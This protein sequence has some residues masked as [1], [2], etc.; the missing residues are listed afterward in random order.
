MVSPAGTGAET[1]DTRGVKADRIPAGRL[2]VMAFTRVSATCPGSWDMTL[3]TSMVVSDPDAE[4]VAHNDTIIKIRASGLIKS[5]RWCVGV[6]I[7]IFLQN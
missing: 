5:V 3:P 6:C 2:S 1:P 7:C 4:A